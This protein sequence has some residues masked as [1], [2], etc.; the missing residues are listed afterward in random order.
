GATVTLGGDAEGSATVA[1]DGTWSVPVDLGVGSYTVTA[2]QSRDDEESET[3]SVTF[4]V[5]PAA[6]AITS[7]ASGS[8]TESDA[9]TAVSG[10]GI[11]G[12]EVIVTVNGVEV[13]SALVVDGE[14]TVALPEALGVGEF[15]ISAVQ[16]VDGVTS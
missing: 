11:E 7:P 16:I 8:V 15:V 3:V 4:D 9:P 1:A 6:P 5:I 2:T 12:A 13:G 10:T 14:W